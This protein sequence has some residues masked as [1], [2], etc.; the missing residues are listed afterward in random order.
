[1]KK[2][3]A[4]L[5]G[6]LLLSCQEKSKDQQ[7]D[8]TSIQELRDSLTVNL[9]SF[10]EDGYIKGFGVAIVNQDTTLY[11]Q[12]FGQSHINK[13]KPYT[14]GS[15]QNIAS[16]SKT[17]I[18][19]ALLKAQELGKLELDDP[20]AKY[21]PFEVSNPFY[22]SQAITIRHLATHTSS[23]QD[24][25]TYNTKSY[26]LQGAKAKDSTPS[27]PYV[28]DFNAPD[29]MTDLGTFLE[30]FL[31]PEGAWYSKT[32]FLDKTPGERFEY[33]NVGATLAAYIVERA[34]GTDYREFT[35]DHI[36]EPLQMSATGWS[37]KAIDTTRLTQLFTVEGNKIPD[38]TLITY[39]DGGLITSVEDKAKYL[40]ELI[41]AYN[42]KG[43]LLTQ[44]SYKQF[45]SPMLSKA[46]FDGEARSDRPFDDEYNS[47]L[48][49]GHTPIGYLGHTGG[50]PG[51]STFMFFNP[52]T[53]IGKLLF[54]NTDLDRD[55]ANQFYAIWDTMGEY[56]TEM[57]NA[58]RQ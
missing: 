17:L 54:V 7:A 20:I 42:G 24:G 28:D 48:F 26:V 9:Q 32:H 3:V 4:I 16:V 22:S 47:G 36:L 8:Q 46:N 1:M 43:T 23:I 33:S 13:K 14:K 38:Y 49:L 37:T 19:I 52:K 35:K 2:P 31:S 21:L 30:N 29:K 10:L 34:T 40:K 27:P 15:L 25:E 5:L 58:L 12:G 39:P 11:L 51:V 18:G 50:D 41:R 6:I 57:D 44:K 56:E 55:G 45:F 53:N